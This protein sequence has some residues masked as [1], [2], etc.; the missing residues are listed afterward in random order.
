MRE[1]F[2]DALSDSAAMIP[3]L[4]LLY[5]LVE[6]FERRLGGKISHALEKSAKVGPALGAAFGCIPQCGFSVVASALYARRVITKGTLL[7]VFLAT[8]D[9]AIPVI[10]AQPGKGKFVVAVLV[11]KLIIGVVAGY[12]IDLA[13]GI[14]SRGKVERG[15][16][17]PVEALHDA[18]C[19]KHDL[20]GTIGKWQWLTHPLIH[21]AKIFLFIMAVTFAINALIAFVG[22]DNLGRVLL[23]QHLLQPFLAALIG[24]I[25]NCAASVA[26]A[27][28]FLKGGLSYGSAIAGLCSSAGLGIL[29]LLKE[30]HDSRDTIRILI[31]LVAISTVAGIAI[32]LLYG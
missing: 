21:T 31:L 14:L 8:S 26:I 28:L 27:E 29:V 18:G 3:F 20:S 22:E 11:T 17:I 15:H 25:P 2:L 9:E 16:K 19:C 7:A 6:L 5:F 24:L 12:A 32:Q 30:N 4:L 13:L 10:L 1:L 23:K